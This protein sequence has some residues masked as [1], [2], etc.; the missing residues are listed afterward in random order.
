M[1]EARDI[2]LKSIVE[3]VEKRLDAYLHEERC[4]VDLEIDGAVDER[5]DTLRIVVRVSKMASGPQIL[6]WSGEVGNA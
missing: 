5:Q 1:G 2:V 3:D 4:F 6:P